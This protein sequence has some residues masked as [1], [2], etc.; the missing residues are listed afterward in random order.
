MVPEPTVVVVDDDDA[1]RDSL[2]AMLKTEGFAV[3]IFAAAADFVEGY[4]GLRLLPADRS[5]HARD[6]RN[7]AADRR[8]SALRR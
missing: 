2:Q 1:V 7:R 4:R 3:E 5:A 6:R 8:A